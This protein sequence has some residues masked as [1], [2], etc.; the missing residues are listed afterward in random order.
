MQEVQNETWTISYWIK[1]SLSD[2]CCRERKNLTDPKTPG[3]E[4]WHRSVKR[5]TCGKKHNLLPRTAYDAESSLKPY[6]PIG[7]EEEWVSELSFLWQVSGTR[8]TEE[9]GQVARADRSHM[10]HLYHHVSL[11]VVHKT[12]HLQLWQ[13]GET[14]RQGRRPGSV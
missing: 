11:P 8:P 5:W 7:E 4:L 3:V 14:G 12:Q 2:S 13:E 6:V 9:E 10:L 1:T